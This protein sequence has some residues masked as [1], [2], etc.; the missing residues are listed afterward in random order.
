MGCPHNDMSTNVCVYLCAL[1][2][3]QSPV[4]VYLKCT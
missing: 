1:V 4:A 2:T 3:S